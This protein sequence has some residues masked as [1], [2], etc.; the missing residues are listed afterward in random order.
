VEISREHAKWNDEFQVLHISI[1]MLHRWPIIEHE[2]YSGNG[3]NDKKQ[4]RDPSHAPG[5]SEL[6]GTFTYLGRMEVQEHIADYH[7]NLISLCVR[8]TV[9]ENGPP[10]LRMNHLLSK[11]FFI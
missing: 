4:E 10:Y 9:P 5:V 7:K 3:E 6:Q 11:R 8:T 1:G 2:E